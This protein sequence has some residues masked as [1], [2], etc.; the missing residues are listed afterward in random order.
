MIRKLDTGSSA[1]ITQNN[2]DIT[3]TST[4]SKVEDAKQPVLENAK[5]PVEDGKQTILED[6]KAPAEVRTAQL[7]ENALSGQ[8]MAVRLSSLIPSSV[9][10]ITARTPV[11]A[12]ET[13]GPR[14]LSRWKNNKGDDVKE[15]QEQINTWRGANGKDPIGVDG[16]FGEETEK[17]VIQFQKANGLKPD[18]IIG[19]NTRARL[20]LE[21]SENFKALP[22][23]T[24][25]DVRDS[26]GKYQKDPAARDNLKNL[27]TSDAFK[28]MS[29]EGQDL[30]LKKLA[31]NP[32]DANTARDV[33]DYASDRSYM[34]SHST[35]KNMD[36]AAK[37]K[38][39]KQFDSY[40]DQPSAR[41]N[42]MWIAT[43][44]NFAKLN[45]DQK[46]KVLKAYGDNP[47]PNASDDL[48]KVIGNDS[49]AS[50]DEATKNKS[51]DLAGKYIKDPQSSHELGMLFTEEKFAKMSNADKE[52]MLNVFDNATPASRKE[53]RELLNKEV[54]GKSALL[55]TTSNG[56]TTLDNLDRLAR[57]PLQASIT[58]LAGAPQNKSKVMEDVIKELNKPSQN[59]NQDNKGTCTVTSMTHTLAEHNPAEYARIVT[60]LATTGQSK[61]ANGDTITPPADGF[62]QDNSNRSVSERLFQSALMN[63][64]RPGAGYQN[65]NKAGFPQAGGG[66]VDNGFPPNGSNLGALDNKRVM[67]GLFNKKM[68]RYT[69]KLPDRIKT[70]IGKGNGPVFTGVRWG[71][72][73]HAIEITKIEGGRVYFRNPWGPG[74]VAPNGTASGSAA[75]NSNAGP[76]RQTEDQSNGIESMT[77]DQFNACSNDIIVSK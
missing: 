43:D 50:M 52:K 1:A 45:A 41:Q 4:S 55:A 5:Q 13:S 28:G 57:T 12:G 25:K 49:F 20:E 3:D 72:G 34:E 8:T 40:A 62:P 46:D 10:D 58:D 29:R 65:W 18:G 32:G 68:E 35:F 17:A 30:A 76:L 39:L 16:K 42:L 23:A 71:N 53:L 22:D 48:R 73:N 75:N 60:D 11:T 64:G 27:A 59:L 7:S 44:S 31:T 77:I 74:A 38:V 70:E 26:M 54:N 2:S 24:K 36:P 9:A 66:T 67:E 56:T 63:Y 69:D 21:N 33:G 14:E 47:G 19:A 6:A 15:M 51:L 37:E 61:I